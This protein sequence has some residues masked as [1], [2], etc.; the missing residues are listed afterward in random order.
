MSVNRI[1]A[2]TSLVVLALIVAACTG[3]T[4]ESTTTS[5]TATT[6]PT[7]TTTS[8]PETLIAATCDD[9]KLAVFDLEQSVSAAFT[10]SE[11]TQLSDEET[12]L[13][14][15]GPIVGFYEGL[16]EIAADAPDE[17]AADMS[18][19]ATVIA[20]LRD[21]LESGDPSAL[22]LDASEA[23]FDLGNEASEVVD[24]WVVE[25]CD[26]DLSLDPDTL[27]A[28]TL[29]SAA[30]G[31][32]GEGL[33]DL[34]ESLEDLEG[35]LGS[36]LG[37]FGTPKLAYGDDPELDALW[38]AC[39][40]GD[41]TACDDLYWQSFGAYEVV[42]ATC[43][44]RAPLLGLGGGCQDRLDPDGPMAYVD[45]PE[46]DL[47]WDSCE[48]GDPFA[49]DN[50]V[51]SAPIGSEYVVFGAGCG[52]A[53]EPVV[54]R[55]CMSPDDPVT[56]GDDSTLDNLWDACAAGDGDACSDLYFDSPFSSV[57]EAMGNACGVLIERDQDCALVV[58]LLTA[59]G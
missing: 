18:A 14:V 16:S 15:L 27:I 4:S 6:A 55:Q 12:A 13:A 51:S 42:A 46:L 48:A 36:D 11:S 32:L 29:F 7:T 17:I 21:A 57:Y 28:T 59:T 38:D 3:E 22:G 53:A 49:C 25:N 2:T 58:E 23:P 26:T 50:L 44:G 41:D 20:P 37:D 1:A 24:D 30:F 31:A 47:L 10:G 9:I 45:D 43:G 8:N 33:A 35:G 34:S 5:S 39:L 19:L 52:G 56:Y 54:G 40:D